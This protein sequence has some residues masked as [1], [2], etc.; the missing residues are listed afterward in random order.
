MEFEED[1]RIRCLRLSSGR[2]YPPNG[3]WGDRVY[4]A[5]TLS[6]RHHVTDHENDPVPSTASANRFS[7]ICR[8]ASSSVQNARLAAAREEQSALFRRRQSFSLL[9]DRAT[10]ATRTTSRTSRE[11]NRHRVR[12]LGRDFICLGSK[13]QTRWTRAD[14]STLKIAGLGTKRIMFENVDEVSSMELKDRLYKEFPKLAGQGFELLRV[15]VN[16]T[17]L[18]EIPVDSS[19]YT[20]LYLSSILQSAKIFVRPIANDLSLAPDREVGMR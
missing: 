12:S 17:V 19:G 20:P 10:S 5:S 3:E 1:G 11:K 7:D 15:K 16:T 9:T 8:A 18:E 6:G 13:D 2:V 4:H 14:H